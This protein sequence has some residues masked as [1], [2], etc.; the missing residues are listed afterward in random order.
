MSNVLAFISVKGGVG[1]TTLALET[2]SSLAN[3]FGKR[4]LLVDA[5]FSAPNVGLYLGMNNGVTLHDVLV[6]V[7]MHNAIYDAHGFDVVSASMNFEHEVDMYQLKKLL[8]KIK[9][10]YD[11]VILDSSPH[12]SEMTPVVIAADRIFVVSSG[13]HVT[14]NT[15]LKAANIAKKQN[16]PVEGIIINRIRDEKHEESL[17]D[18][19]KMTSLPVLAR[20]RDDKRVIRAVF[21][22]TPLGLHD[23]SSHAAKEIERFVSALVGV[24]ETPSLLHRIF[25]KKHFS[26][27]TVN[28]DFMRHQFYECRL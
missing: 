5:N 20:I 26:K 7:G 10:Q 24:P 6:G 21:H 25:P 15:S 27:E 22:R 3:K 9:K 17:R 16:T 18:I 1:K 4:V 23:D 14:L 12:Y 8:E 28:R 13:D 2:A 11:F 19:E